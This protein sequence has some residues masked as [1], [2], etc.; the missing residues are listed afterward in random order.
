MHIHVLIRVISTVVTAQP[1]IYS[2]IIL[3][4]AS[5]LKDSNRY[6][7][8]NKNKVDMRFINLV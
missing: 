1:Q 3:N 2:Y 4:D 8:K 6:Q 7:R 5:R